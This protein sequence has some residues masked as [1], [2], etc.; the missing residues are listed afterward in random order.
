MPARDGNGQEMMSSPRGRLLREGAW[1]ALGQGLSAIAAIVSIRIMTELLAPEQFGRLTLLI[2]LAALALGLASTPILQAVF[3]FY[4]EWQQAGQVGRLRRVCRKASSKAVM[5]AASLLVFA[6]ILLGSVT[7]EPLVVF[8]LV[9]LLLV[10][11][12]VRSF[13]LAFLNAARRQASA[14]MVLAADAWSRP[15]V[16]VVVVSLL[17]PSAEAGLAGYLLGA[18]LALGL[19]KVLLP[20]NHDLATPSEDMN[21]ERGLALALRNYSLPLIPLAFFGWFGGTGDRYVIAGMLSL[22]EVGMYAAAFGLASR[23]FLML[24]GVIEQTYRPVLHTAVAEADRLAIETTKRR[25]L[26][27]TG[28]VAVSGVVCFFGLSK[29]IATLLLAEE[30]RAA[31]SLMPWIA[32]GYG[33]LMIAGVYTRLCY[34]FDATR[35]ILLLSVVA[36]LIGLITLF[37]GLS[38]FGLMG[39]ALVV[40]VRYFIEMSMAWWLSR[41]AEG[42]FFKQ[43]KH[44]PH[45]RR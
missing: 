3:R 7:G 11:D 35:S 40:P 21:A 28:A 27:V 26:A 8:F 22:G 39:A 13:E 42:K 29:V 33:F 2:A 19:I 14:A 12:A 6:G 32:M 24:A 36:S 9:A 44:A 1:V 18:G 38:A 5:L 43:A 23:P 30:Y 37:V 16:A 4:P 17:G 20:A 31:A 45:V 10:V 34:A 15:I 25:V 41:R